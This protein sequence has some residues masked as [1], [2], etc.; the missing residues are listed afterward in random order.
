MVP[1]NSRRAHTRK[2][3]VTPHRMAAFAVF[4]GLGIAACSPGGASTKYS[5]GPAATNMA[6]GP[7]N[8]GSQPTTSPPAAPVGAGTAAP[9]GVGAKVSIT[10]FAFDPAVLTVKARTTVTWTNNDIVAH[11]VTFTD[12]ANSPVLNHGETFSRTFPAAGTY[13]YICSIHP[14]MHGTVVVTP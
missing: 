8:M 14:F 5:A 9:V 1:I 12:V 11:T 3:K 13:A 4:A 6:A 10:N 2:S 7:M